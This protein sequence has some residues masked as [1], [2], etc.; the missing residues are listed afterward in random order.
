KLTGPQ[1]DT[2]KYLLQHSEIKKMQL[3]SPKSHA[4]DVPPIIFTLYYNDQKLSIQTN[5]PPMNMF[6]L[7]AFLEAS[8]QKVALV[9][10]P[11][12]HQFVEENEPLYKGNGK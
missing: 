5:V 3:W 11:K 1:L 2:L 7:R 8:Y 10:D 6:D 4:M 9:R 12:K